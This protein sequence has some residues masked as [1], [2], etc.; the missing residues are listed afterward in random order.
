MN[1]SSSGV[2]P[3]LTTQFKPNRSL[4]LEVT[5]S[6]HAEPGDGVHAW[7]GTAGSSS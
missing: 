1:A 6:P 3:A 5:G 7:P 2:F 4:N